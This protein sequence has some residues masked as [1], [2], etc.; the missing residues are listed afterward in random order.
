MVKVNEFITQW[1]LIVV[2]NQYNWKTEFILW[3]FSENPYNHTEKK[4]KFNAWGQKRIDITSTNSLTCVLPWIERLKTCEKML[5]TEIFQIILRTVFCI[6]CGFD[7]APSLICGNKMPTRCN[8]W[9]LLQILLLD[10][11]VSG[12]TMPIIRSSR[13]LY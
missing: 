12:T 11:Y 9:F 4:N 3:S 2:L 1:N 13:V 8:R 6:W 10:Q 7:R 5:C